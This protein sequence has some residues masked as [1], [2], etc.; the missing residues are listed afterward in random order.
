MN[1][2]TLLIIALSLSTLAIL[3]S[4]YGIYS[5]SKA[6]RWRKLL[7]DDSEQPQNLEEIIAAMTTKIKSL[8]HRS[9]NLETALN[10]LTEVASK[11]VQ[12]TGLVRFNSQADDGGNLSFCLAMLDNHQTGVVVTSL[13]GRQ[14][15]R[16][17]SKRI[18]D[19]KSESPLSEEETNAIIQ[20]VQS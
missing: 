15:N 17:Y 19:G 3:F 7:E 14:Q 11:A 12:K 4:S 16:I 20:A 2:Q 1:T 13:H 18:V 6:H 8:E 9:E 10:A 5:A